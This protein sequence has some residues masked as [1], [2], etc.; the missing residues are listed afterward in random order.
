[1]TRKGRLYTMAI[2]TAIGSLR[3]A[4][5]DVG[6]A[7][8]ELPCANGRGLLGWKR[9]HAPDLVLEEGFEPNRVAAHQI[10]D[11]L[12]AKRQ[13]FDLPLDLRGT[14]FQL[15][16]YR[17]VARIGYGESRSYAEIAAA[18]GRPRA[19]RAVGAA[20]GANPVPLVIPCHR[21]IGSSGQLQGYAGG[22]ELKARLLA[23]ES[24]SRPGQG[25]LL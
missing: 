24:A 7:Y 10:C 22:L 17:E 12:E 2:D 6:L 3:L 4:S 18:V 23:M 19:V 8:V 21:V 20:N 25:Q 16:V 1:M 11:F 5:S 14:G 9:R 15:D 13:V